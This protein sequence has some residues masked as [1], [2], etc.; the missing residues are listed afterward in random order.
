MVLRLQVKIKFKTDPLPFFCV[1]ISPLKFYLIFYSMNTSKNISVVADLQIRKL[2]LIEWLARLDD[3]STSREIEAIRKKSE[4]RVMP[5][6]KIT[7]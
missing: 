4:K 5:Q 2:T 3:V 1:L 6:L 7:T